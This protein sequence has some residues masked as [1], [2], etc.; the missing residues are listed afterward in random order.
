MIG[1]A[2]WTFCLRM[3]VCQRSGTLPAHTAALFSE[4]FSYTMLSRAFTGRLGRGISTPLAQNMVG[5]ASGIL[6][7]PLQTTFMSPLRKAALEQQKS[8]MVLFWGGQIAPILKHREATKLMQSLIEETTEIM[9][10]GRNQAHEKRNPLSMKRL[11]LHIQP[12]G[13]FDN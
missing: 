11:I 4:A 9:D 3:L 7:F 6:P 13:K 1:L 2:D 8:A 10:K 12:V 5:K